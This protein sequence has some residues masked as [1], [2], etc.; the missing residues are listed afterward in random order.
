MNHN[1]LKA[2]IFDSYFDKH[3]GVIAFVRVFSGSL[4]K[5]TQLNFL[6]TGLK[7]VC[8]EVGYFRPNMVESPVINCGEVGYLITGLKEIDNV[9]VGD[10]ISNYDDKLLALP[11][12]KQVK[13]KVFASIFTSSQDEYP[14][15]RDAINKLKL[16]DS[17]LYFEV[18]N[19]PA[20]GFGFRTGFLGLLHLEIVK[21][22]LEREFNLDLIVTTPSVEYKALLRKD[23]DLAPI[24]LLK[25]DMIDYVKSLEFK[26]IMLEKLKRAN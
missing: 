21:E 10:T 1:V 23:D 20:L 5:D 25:K 19:I 6:A 16:N 18:E 12:Y 7:A 2:L 3:R 26:T 4:K 24:E 9:K 17:S 22:R 11:G 8:Q 13:P 15:L 14:K